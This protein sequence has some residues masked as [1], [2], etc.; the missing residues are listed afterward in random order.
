MAVFPDPWDRAGESAMKDDC[1][2]VALKAIQK[3]GAGDVSC[4]EM[5]NVGQCGEKLTSRCPGGFWVLFG[6]FWEFF[7]FRL[8]FVKGS[9]SGVCCQL[10]LE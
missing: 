6:V 7:G 3:Y 1:C 10:S 9:A 8:D 5:R 2:A 4:R